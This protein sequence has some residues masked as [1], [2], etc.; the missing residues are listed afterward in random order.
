M[1]R[2]NLLM[3]RKIS[4]N[5]LTW[6]SWRLLGLVSWVA[7]I[8]ELK[9]PPRS[10]KSCCKV[11][12]WRFKPPSPFQADLVPLTEEVLMGSSIPASRRPRPGQTAWL[13]PVECKISLV[14]YEALVGCMLVWPEKKRNCKNN[15]VVLGVVISQI[16]HHC[17]IFGKPAAG[18]HW[19]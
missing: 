9:T 7:D 2:Y 14:H 6:Y 19:T 3:K 13:K 15:I 11:H 5:Y 18:S 12:N 10:V 8:A 16:C 17:K 1:H 4:N